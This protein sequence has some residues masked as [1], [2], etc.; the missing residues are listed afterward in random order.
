[1]AAS[2]TLSTTKPDFESLVLQ[3]QVFLNARATWSDLLTSSTGQTLIEMMAAVGAFNQF[4][5]ESAAREGFLEQAVRAS[6]VYAIVRM[7]GVR[8]SR[9]TP[10]GTDVALTRSGDAT[11][12]MVI[13]R[14]TQ[15]TVNG[16]PFFNRESVTFASGSAQAAP[17]TLYEGQIKTQTIAADS[18]SFREIFLN[19][20]GFGVSDSDIEVILSNPSLGT[21]DLWSPIV[22]GIWTAEPTD[23]VYYDSTAGD[24]D[25]VLAFGDG[26]S[27]FLPGLGNNITINYAVTTG[28]VGS[29]GGS[30]LPVALA[31]NALIGGTSLTQITG[32]A[33]EKTPAYYRSTAPYIY[34]SRRRAVSPA[35]YKA[36]ASSYPGV[37]SVV[38]QTQK[39]VAPGDLR[40]MNVVRLCVLPNSEDAFTPAEWLGFLAWFRSRKHAAIDIQAFNPIQVMADIEVTLLLKA[41]GNPAEIVPTVEANIR[42]LFAKDKTTLGRRI[43]RSDI[44][45]ACRVDLVDYVQIVT[46]T[47]DDLV[48]PSGLYFYALGS[49][50]VIPQY[51]ERS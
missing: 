27:G 21:S 36:I 24:G 34:K 50:K 11:Y 35:D 14:F 30:G 40:W 51:S 37:A 41:S 12:P 33:D 44:D 38:V 42:A 8:I 22:D 43:A 10:A 23:K 19:E 15:F 46:P 3:L 32:G 5:I 29:V 18:T 4:A 25:V 17:I 45:A 13:R 1:M 6:S 48:L 7:L 47:K 26:H 49:L 31:S 20:P 39:D 16:R 28:T 2:L 9:K